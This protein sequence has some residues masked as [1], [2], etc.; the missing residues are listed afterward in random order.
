M[1]KLWKLLQTEIKIGKDKWAH[2]FFGFLTALVTFSYFKD[3][4]RTLKEKLA[5]TAGIGFTLWGLKE[6][7]DFFIAGH[8][9]DI[10]DL[11]FSC[12]GI[13]TAVIWQKYTKTKSIS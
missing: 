2:L 11:F 7:L 8:L 9:A 4:N 13:I 6:V 12:A 1:G 3:Q 10:N 5:L